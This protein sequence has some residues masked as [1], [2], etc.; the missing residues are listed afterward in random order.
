MITEY[1]RDC[2]TRFFII[3]KQKGDAVKK[4]IDMKERSKRCIVSEDAS[5][6]DIQTGS[7]Q[8]IAEALEVFN[9]HELEKIR[10]LKQQN[11]DIQT[12]TALLIFDSKERRNKGI[13]KWFRRRVK[14]IVFNKQHKTATTPVP[15]IDIEH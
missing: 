9:K 1:S 4:E 2:Y 5:V 10:I 13:L 3:T 11:A 15:L 6:E 8:R 14:N 7:L 12:I